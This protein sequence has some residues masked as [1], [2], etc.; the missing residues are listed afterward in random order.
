[1]FFLLLVLLFPAQ[2]LGKKVG[3]IHMHGLLESPRENINF[4]HFIE[5]ETGIPVRLI[6]RNNYI[7]SLG[8]IKY[9]ASYLLG[10]VKSIAE[11]YDEVIAVGYSQGGLIWRT[12]IEMWQDHNVVMFISLASPQQ[13]VYGVPPILLLFLPW[14]RT[15]VEN[16]LLPSWAYSRIGQSIGVFNYYRDPTREDI[17]LE[18]NKFLPYINN[19]RGTASEIA[20]Q[21]EN[22]LRLSKLVLVGGPGEN[23]I[24]P[25]QSTI[26]G[27]YSADKSIVEMEETRVYQD[28][29]FGLKT[30]KE[31]GRLEVCVVEGISHLQFRDNKKMLTRCILPF[32]KPYYVP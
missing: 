19:E 5:K 1:M 25:W 2:T 7:A 10:L 22:F 31:S 9:Q 32:L 18:K 26:F 24:D 21:K 4:K 8:P 11:E 29:L 30:L 12:M 13:G 23:V 27:Y 15:Y 16:G 17:Y 28:D 6:D 3:I 14:L 20:R